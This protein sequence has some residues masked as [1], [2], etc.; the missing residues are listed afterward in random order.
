MKGVNELILNEATM[1]EAL[2]AWIN[3]KMVT[4]DAIKVT[5]VEKVTG[6]DH[7]S[8]TFKIIIEEVEATA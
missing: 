1:I 7:Y 3:A 2:Q 6:S 8:R 4:A 5:S